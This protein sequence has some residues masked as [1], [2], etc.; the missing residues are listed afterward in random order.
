MSARIAWLGLGAIGVLLGALFL[1]QAS[2]A[3]TFSN[4]VRGSLGTPAAISGTLEETTPLLIAGLAVFVALRAG[5]FNIGVEGQLLVGALTCAAVAIRVPGWFGVALGVVAAMTAGALWALPAG[6]I[7]AYRGGH[8]VITTIMLNNIAVQLTTALVAG[9]LKDPAQQATTTAD[10][11]T[12]LPYMIEQPPLR[13]SPSILLGVGL[14]IALAIWLRRTVAGYELQAVG[15]NKTAAKVAGI[16]AERVTVAAMSASGALGGLAGAV[17]V[18]AY[19]HRFYANFSPGYGFTALGVALLAGTSA[20]AVLPAALLFGV[21]E[22]GG[23]FINTMGIPKGITLVV[24]ALLVL[25]AG[26]VRYR[27]ARSCDA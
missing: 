11:P 21:L 1:A 26:A 14:A 25:I 3:E 7:K 12:P 4:F 23:T 10:I 18:V 20:Y 19:E 2:P 13:I 17:M 24:L 6:L 22:R 5:L 9:P 27:E 8:E 15:A 16:A